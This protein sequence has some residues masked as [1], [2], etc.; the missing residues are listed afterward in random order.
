[1][2][3]SGN[4]CVVLVLINLRVNTDKLRDARDAP[5]ITNDDIIELVLI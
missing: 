5:S 2:Q 4:F 1:M 3:Q